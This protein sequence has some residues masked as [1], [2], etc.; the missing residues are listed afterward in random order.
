[1]HT[2][3]G[4]IERGVMRTM[5]PFRFHY[6]CPTHGREEHASGFGIIDTGAP[7]SCIPMTALPAGHV[8]WDDLAVTGERF[9]TGY[10]EGEARPWNLRMTVE[11]I[12]IATRIGVHE[13]SIPDLPIVGLEDLGR[14]YR[15]MLDWGHR[16]PLLHLEP[17]RAEAMLLPTIDHPGAQPLRMP[18]LDLI[19]Y[20]DSV[21]RLSQDE[22]RFDLMTDEEAGRHRFGVPPP[23]LEIAPGDLAPQGPRASTFPVRETAPRLQRPSRAVRRAQARSGTIVRG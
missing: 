2:Y 13:R 12:P 1:M 21:F 23:A 7:F 14:V 17:Y 8:A 11:G 10:G 20:E 15:I 6:Q 9:R 19:R 22:R 3:R 5:V 4:V 18:E 16:P